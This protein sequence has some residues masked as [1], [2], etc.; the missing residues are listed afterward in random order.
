M[1]DDIDKIIAEVERLDHCASKD[2]RQDN[3]RIRRGEAAPLLTKSAHGEPVFIAYDDASA[4]V[5]YRTAAPILAAEVKRLRAE[6]LSWTRTAAMHE[7]M[8]LEIA[9]ENEDLRPTLAAEQGRQEGAPIESNE[10]A[11]EYDYTRCIC[12][13]SVSRW[14]PTCGEEYAERRAAMLAADAATG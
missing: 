2:W 8:Y 7:H 14:C 4:A 1:N 3:C 10:A 11:D 9:A 6:V 13:D 5:Y 12:L